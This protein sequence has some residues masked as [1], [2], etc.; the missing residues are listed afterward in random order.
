M[1]YIIFSCLFTC[2]IIFV[3]VLSI[4]TITLFSTLILFFFE[5]CLGLFWQGANLL[6]GQLDIFLLE[7]LLL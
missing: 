3:L 5:E 4:E 6:V 2:I 1:S 7:Q